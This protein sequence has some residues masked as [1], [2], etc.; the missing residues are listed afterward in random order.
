VLDEVSALVDTG[1]LP[2][3]DVRK[4]PNLLA[5]LVEGPDALN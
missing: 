1:T 5:S 4:A 2:V 3:S